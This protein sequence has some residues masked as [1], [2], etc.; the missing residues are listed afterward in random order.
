MSELEYKDFDAE[1]EFKAD[2]SGGF[3]GYFARFGNVDRVNE[4]IE[5]GAF[6]NLNEFM[7]DGWIGVSHDTKSLPVAMI[8]SAKQDDR[9][10]LITGRFHSHAAAQACRSVIKERMAAGKAV[11]GSIG[12]KVD[13]SKS[14]RVEGKSI[15]RLKALRVM[16]AS[17]VNLPA[18]PL[19]SVISAKSLDPD[20]PKLIAIEDIETLLAEYKAGRVISK[21]NYNKLKDMHAK[22]G[23]AHATLGAFLN[24]HDPDG[25]IDEP[26]D[27]TLT[28]GGGRVAGKAAQ[29]KKLRLCNVWGRAKVASLHTE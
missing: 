23:D 4:I 11:K 22:L 25:G 2:D 29:L 8:D 27:D 6:K 28:G 16:E 24:Q 12:Y 26:D 5:P 17:F 14:D 13:D 10:L 7:A 3:S 20:A 15:K 1:L 21:G 9:G 18:N 19:A